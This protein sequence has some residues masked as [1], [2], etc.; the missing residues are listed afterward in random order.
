MSAPDM[1]TNMIWIMK[2]AR[3]PCENAHMGI[4]Q[5]RTV[6]ENEVFRLNDSVVFRTPEVDQVSSDI[7]YS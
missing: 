3:L 6:A 2:S 1:K 7:D 4:D 5:V